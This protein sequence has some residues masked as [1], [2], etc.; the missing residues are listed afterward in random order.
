M[1]PADARERLR[2]EEDETE[3]GDFLLREVGEAQW[4][5][6]F[7]QTQANERPCRSNFVFL[8]MFFY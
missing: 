6:T 8:T 3:Q 1:V 5:A 7:E 2:D 4:E